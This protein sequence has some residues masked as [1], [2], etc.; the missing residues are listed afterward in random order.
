MATTGTG[1]ECQCGAVMATPL[2]DLGQGTSRRQHWRCPACGATRCVCPEPAR[3]AI[4]WGRTGTVVTV[5]VA[6]SAADPDQAVGLVTGALTRRRSRALAFRVTRVNDLR[7]F[8]N[9]TT[10]GRLVSG[11]QLD[12]W[13]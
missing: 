8:G 7:N 2:V 1:V 10:P 4:P 5:E 6:V 9:R 12:L 13:A 11:G 3:G